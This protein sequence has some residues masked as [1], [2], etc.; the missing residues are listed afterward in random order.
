MSDRTHSD[1]LVIGGGVIG[2]ACAH[3][4]SRAGRSVRILEQGKI[5]SG[6]S[7]GNCGLVFVSDLVPLCV[8]GVVRK[9]LFTMLRRN[10]PL[11]IKPSFDLSRMRW[12]LRFA[13]Q[14]R[15][16][17]VRHAIRARESIHKS[18]KLLF[19]ELVSAGAIEAEYE[20]RGVLLVYRSEAAMRD[21]EWI[22]AQL[23][24][25]GFAAEAM[26]GKA[27]LDFEP[28]LREDVFGAWHHR[29]D[30]H[31]RPDRLL[32]SWRQA[33]LLAGVAIEEDCGLKRFR[34]ATASRP[35]SPAGVSF[36]LTV[37]FWRRAPGRP[38]WPVSS[39][40]SC[41]SSP[42]RATAS[43]WAGRR[44]APARPA[45]CMNAAWWP[46]PGRAGTAWAG[47]WNFAASTSA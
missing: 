24:P 47:R 25:Y 17:H 40:S 7:P 39:A 46:P 6:A 8:P 37:T 2:L 26:V 3:Y 12:L 16:E 18:S 1:V 32:K 20:Q 36:R 23:Q 10:S 11:Y 30:S 27:L 31:L 33:L 29:A 35:Q 44:C 42:A 22:N 4:L 19:A 14:C 34:P 38:R 28:A 41:R 9:E 21:Y 5:G 43:P 15:D 13:R 45:T